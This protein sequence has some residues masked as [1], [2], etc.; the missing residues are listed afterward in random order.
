MEA[1]KRYIHW[2]IGGEWELLHRGCDIMEVRCKD[3]DLIFQIK[4]LKEVPN[5]HK[6]SIGP[7]PQLYHPP[8]KPQ[9]TAR[10]PPP[11]WNQLPHM[12]R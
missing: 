2:N 9:P 5:K 3:P 4:L 1:G 8:A 6:V 12:F 11:Q 10:L 7:N